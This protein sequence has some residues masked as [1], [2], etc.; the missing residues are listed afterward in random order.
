M[1]VVSMFQPALV[2]VDNLSS[3]RLFLLSLLVS[4]PGEDLFLSTEFRL[5][6]EAEGAAAVGPPDSAGFVTDSG[7]QTVCTCFKNPSEFTWLRKM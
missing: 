1:G 7:V 6:D 5:E 2:N 4:S 3:P